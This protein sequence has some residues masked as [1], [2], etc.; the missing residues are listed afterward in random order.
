MKTSSTITS[1]GQITLPAEM[2]RRLGL[3]SGERVKFV[4]KGQELV[5]SKDNYWEELDAFRKE[6]SAKV[7]RAGLAGLSIEEIR[8]GMNEAKAK[9]YK[10]HYD[11]R[12]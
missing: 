9:Y 2:R 12:P 8:Q 11:S 3:K 4:I 7:R 6:M 10:E 5:V 1:K